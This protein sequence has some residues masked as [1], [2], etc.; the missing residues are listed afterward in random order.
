[1]FTYRFSSHDETQHAFSCTQVFIVTWRYFGMRVN[2]TKRE[3]FLFTFN[4]PNVN[5]NSFGC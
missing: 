2:Q 1:M 3:Y 5:A 4:A